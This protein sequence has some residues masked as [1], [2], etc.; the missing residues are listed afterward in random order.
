M[1][2]REHGRKGK[3]GNGEWGKKGIK[4]GERERN[5]DRDSVGSWRVMETREAPEKIVFKHAF[6]HEVQR[7]RA[8]VA[9]ALGQGQD[10]IKV[11]NC[12]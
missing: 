5:G 10:L 9:L 7:R 2:A 11:I 6:S 12:R 3:N 4:D 8:A 1:K